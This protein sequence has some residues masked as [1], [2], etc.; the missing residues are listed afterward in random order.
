MA[1]RDMK[2]TT[3]IEIDVKIEK[4]KFHNSKEVIQV[5]DVDIEK[6][7]ISDEFAYGKNKETG[8]KYFIGLK[9]GKKI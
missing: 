3:K 4:I 8:A 5:S 1:E 9:T 2:K 6:I 7:L